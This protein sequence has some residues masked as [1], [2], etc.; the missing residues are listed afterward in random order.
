MELLSNLEGFLL[1]LNIKSLQ[2]AS[3]ITFFS[4]ASVHLFLTQSKTMT[5]S[6][7]HYVIMTTAEHSG[8]IASFRELLTY[9]FK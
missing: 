3:Q 5:D 9:G 6:V 8:S 4:A 7:S 2:I 1:F